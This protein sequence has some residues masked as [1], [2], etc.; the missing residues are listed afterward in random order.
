MSSRRCSSFKKPLP[1]GMNL[2]HLSPISCSLLSNWTVFILKAT[3]AKSQMVERIVLAFGWS[4][5]VE[6]AA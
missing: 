4:R 2:I 1:I 3:F 5:S 6:R